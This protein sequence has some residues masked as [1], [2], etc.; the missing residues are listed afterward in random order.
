[1]RVLGMRRRQVV[2]AFAWWSSACGVLCVVVALPIGAAIGR[3]A[4]TLSSRNL[5]VLES[6]SVASSALAMAIV[7]A[8]A[9]MLMISLATSRRPAFASIGRTLRS[10]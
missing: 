10:E 5:G 8:V 9:L 3:T 2:A 4:W 7:A 6:F 1:M